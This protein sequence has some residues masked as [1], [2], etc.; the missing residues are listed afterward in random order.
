VVA[1]LC[2]KWLFFSCLVRL[3]LDEGKTSGGA[4]RGRWRRLGFAEEGKEQLLRR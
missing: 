2:V 1:F 4:R 3:V